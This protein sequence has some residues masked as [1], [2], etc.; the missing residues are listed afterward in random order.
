MDEEKFAF[1]SEEV[2]IAFTAFSGLGDI[3]IARKVFDALVELAP[4]C[5][6][7]FACVQEVPATF[8]KAFYGDSKNLNKIIS[9]DKI[10]QKIFQKYDLA[11]QD[12]ANHAILLEWVNTQRLQAMAPELLKSVI[13]I[14][15][16]NKS[17]VFG[18]GSIGLDV[19][20]RNMMT[21]KILHKS[22]YE[23]LS[24]DGALPIYDDKVNIPLLPE[25]KSKFDALK[26]NRYITIYSDIER[27][28]STPKV[29]VWPMHYLHEYVARMKKRFPTVEI[30]QCGGGEDVSI[31]NADR[32]FLEA[33]H[34]QSDDRQA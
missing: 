14:F 29:K 17:N 31:K 33:P 2:S 25:Y 8:V 15:E 32:H 22:C 24:C 27:D 7:D 5:K 11:L 9:R 6:I 10:Y 30:V 28:S 1:E 23:L 12:F 26:L 20:F 4:K 34:Q 18:R 19:A 13:K 16:Y 21:A 3:L